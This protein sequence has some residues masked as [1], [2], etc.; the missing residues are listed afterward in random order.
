MGHAE[1]Q[2]KD[3][4]DNLDQHYAEHV[5]NQNLTEQSEVGVQPEV[6]SAEPNR[7]S[8]QLLFEFYELLDKEVGR[9]RREQNKKHF[10]QKKDWKELMYAADLIFD[11]KRKF[12]TIVRDREARSN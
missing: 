2:I 12:N 6:S 4:M 7:Q 3:Y 10:W 5:E 8:E 9:L 11:A 1:E